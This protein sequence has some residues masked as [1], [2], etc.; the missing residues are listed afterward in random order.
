[1]KNTASYAIGSVIYAVLQWV[2]IVV[3][4]N[5]F[6]TKYVG[7]YTLYLSIL[8][9]CLILLNGGLRVYIASDV[10]NQ[11][12]DASYLKLRMIFV[13]FYFLFFIPSY[14]F[15]EYKDIFSFCYF[16]KG[17]DALSD[18]EYGAWNRAGKQINYLKSQIF[19][20]ASSIF[21]MLLLVFFGG[22]D[23]AIYCIP[24]SLI[25][26]Y[27][28]F[29]RRYSSLDISVAA[30]LKEVKKLFLASYKIGIGALLA[31][32][33]ITINRHIIESQLNLSSLG[34]YI[35]ITY[36]YSLFSLIPLSLCQVSIP[37]IA[38]SK[39]SEFYKL[40]KTNLFLIA[41]FS[42]SYLIFIMMA[43]NVFIN[44]FY[45]ND[46]FYSLLDRFFV[47]LGGIFIFFGV[48]VNSILVSK[49]RTR[50][51]LLINVFL[52]LFST[53]STYFLISYYGLIGTYF[54]FALNSLLLL[55]I[56]SFLVFYYLK[57]NKI[58]LVN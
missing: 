49:K 2:I 55:L 7:V 54:A 5:L 13:C 19:R 38:S 33:T 37:K 56:N 11:F 15:V 42:I 25:L 6:E 21:L 58:K 29:D 53:V 4:S 46:I 26:V 3:I 16:L 50:E 40:L 17:F 24:I 27:I 57:I 51:I 52:F 22:S 34:E 30:T 31:A 12:L 45:S 41:L 18:L 23:I 14:F 39:K 48:F 28:L 36:F 44:Y 8:T 1:M 35:Y 47:S 32:L 43:S 10:S 9:P 20:L